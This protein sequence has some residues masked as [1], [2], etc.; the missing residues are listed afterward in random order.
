MNSGSLATLCET[1]NTAFSALEEKAKVAYFKIGK[2][3]TL[4]D[5]DAEALLD[6]SDKIRIGQWL[7]LLGVSKGHYGITPESS[8]S[9]R[10]VGRKDRIAVISRYPTSP[11]MKGLAFW[12]LASN[13]PFSRLRLACTSITSFL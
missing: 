11:E 2:G 7:W 6:W 5:E 9:M 12:V 1:C 10:E 3:D 13:T 8:T 4:L